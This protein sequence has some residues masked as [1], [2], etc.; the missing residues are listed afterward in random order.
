MKKCD[1][2]SLHHCYA[3]DI[4]DTTWKTQ[5]DKYSKIYLKPYA[6]AWLYICIKILCFSLEAVSQGLQL[7]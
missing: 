7:Y 3:L 6:R 4:K 2:L 1:F 5:K